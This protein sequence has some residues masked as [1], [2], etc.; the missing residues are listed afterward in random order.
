M[1]LL[2]VIYNDYGDVF[3]AWLED[4]S[5]VGVLFDGKGDGI[6]GVGG[7]F[8]DAWWGVVSWIWRGTL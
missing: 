3:V 6:G 5:T 4:K 7:V 2:G 8:G 1:G